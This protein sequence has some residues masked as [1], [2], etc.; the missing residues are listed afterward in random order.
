MNPLSLIPRL[1]AAEQRLEYEFKQLRSKLKTA[2]QIITHISDGF[3]FVTTEGII[4]LYNPA[5]SAITGVEGVVGSL[6]WEH[7]TDTLFGFPLSVALKTGQ[8][9]GRI[10]LELSN[11]KEIEVAPTFI[12]GEGVLLLLN[13]RTEL[14]QLEKSLEESERLKGLGLMAATLAHEIRN[15]L[16]GIR[17]FAELL[18]RDLTEASHV[19]MLEAILDGS[20]IINKL[21]SNVLEYSRP[22][23]LHFVPTQCTTFLQETAEMAQAAGYPCIVKIETESSYSLDRERMQVALLNLIQNGIESGSKAVELVLKSEGVIQI[24]DQGEGMDPEVQGKI[25]TPFFTTKAD[26]TGLG[27][28]EVA[29]VVRAHGWTIHIDSKK[30]KGTCISLCPL[31]TS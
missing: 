23:I 5:A 11:G 16:G 12:Q 15:P 4:S 19:T 17:G 22:L 31:K 9:P 13:D 29:K 28:A 20:R 21:I 8:V 2:H 14:K 24:I 27:L 26:G 30:G 10:D 25:F 1:E 3:L 6:F 18:R 7:F